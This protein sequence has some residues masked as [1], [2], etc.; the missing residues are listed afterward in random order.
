MGSPA[1]EK[2]RAREKDTVVAV[3]ITVAMAVATAVAAG[4][5]DVEQEKKIDDTS[6]LRMDRGQVADRKL[7]GSMT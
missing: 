1:R 4:K 3:T 6:L 2:V 5:Q 7:A